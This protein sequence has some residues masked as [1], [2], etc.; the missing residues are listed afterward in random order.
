M[1]ETKA[2]NDNDRKTGKKPVKN[3]SLY[4]LKNIGKHYRMGDTVVKALDGVSVRIGSG[5]FLSIFGPSGSGK[6]T[7]L[8]IL[9]GL[10]RPT[11]GKVYF[12]GEDISAYSGD[13]MAHFRKKR[14]GFIFQFFN[15]IPTLTS[16]ENVLVSR[17]FDSEV[18]D[19]YARQLLSEVGLNKRIKHLPHQLSGGE[20]QRVAIARALVNNPDVILADEPTGNLDSRSTREVMDLLGKFN[21]KGKTVVLVTHDQA[22]MSYVKRVIRIDDGKVV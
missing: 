1:S 9:G 6:S 14:V 10:D 8:H 7:L 15:L 16:L 20:R 3:I 2:E 17:M 13:R 22:L 19:G 12:K 11:D 21:R 4:R 18:S 5:E